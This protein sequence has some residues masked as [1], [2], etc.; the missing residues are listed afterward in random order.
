LNSPF[1]QESENVYVVFSLKRVGTFCFTY[2]LDQISTHNMVKAELDN[3][4][5]TP[6]SIA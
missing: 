5:I 2:S 6:L 1:S 4:Y 3:A